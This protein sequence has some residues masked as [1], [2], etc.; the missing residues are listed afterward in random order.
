VV[1]AAV[2]VGASVV[3][4]TVVGPE[5]SGAVTTDSVVFTASPSLLEHAA[6]RSD[7]NAATTP[8]VLPRRAIAAS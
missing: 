7:A 5:V 4:G 6:I 3:G 8:S 1:G 2:V